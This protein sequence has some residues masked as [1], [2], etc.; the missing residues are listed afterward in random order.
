M[1]PEKYDHVLVVLS[2]QLR[3]GL[4]LTL[5]KEL[6][7]GSRN[8]E[9]LGALS[10]AVDYKIAT[11]QSLISFSRMFLFTHGSRYLGLPPPH[12]GDPNCVLEPERL[13]SKWRTIPQNCI[14][15]P[16]RG[17]CY[18]IPNMHLQTNAAYYFPLKK[19]GLFF[20]PSK[21]PQETWLSSR[22]QG[23]VDL[24]LI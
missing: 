13:I 9:I 11:V 6:F 20:F 19:R 24:E 5:P 14:F 12:A 15:H 3:A 1:R 18:Y 4:C 10:L 7:S 8:C 23:W 21:Q 16:A 17:G 2:P 22:W